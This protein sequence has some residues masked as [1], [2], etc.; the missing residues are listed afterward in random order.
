MGP[1]TKEIYMF[2]YSRITNVRYFQFLPVMVFVCVA[3]TANARESATPESC[4]PRVSYAMMLANTL[5]QIKQVSG[6]EI[7]GNLME[8]YASPI[9]G[10]WTLVLTLPR[11]LAC[12]IGSG[13]E[14]NF[15]PH[16]HRIS[17]DRNQQKGQP[18]H[19]P[20]QTKN[21]TAQQ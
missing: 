9:S 6:I 16:S 21:T 11:G 18:D 20:Y 3:G 19:D 10:T 2:P 8:L 1:Q 13:K 14:F 7:R 17:H 12:K 5:G 15:E 4:F